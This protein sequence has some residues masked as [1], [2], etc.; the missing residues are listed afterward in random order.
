M[1]ISWLGHSCVRIRSDDVTLITDPY[2]ESLGPSM[3]R[4]RADIV[5]V[6]HEHPHHSHRDGF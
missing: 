2:D 6:S 5:T 4:Q 3:G 1:E